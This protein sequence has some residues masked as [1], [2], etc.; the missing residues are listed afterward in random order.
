MTVNLF[1]IYY[2]S[3]SFE[4]L[5]KGF[6]PLDN[7]QSERP[8]WYEF[9]PIRTYLKNTQ[10]EE[11]AWYGFFSPKFE[12][13]TGFRSDDVRSVVEKTGGNFQVALFSSTWDFIAYFKNVF[14]QGELWHEHITAVSQEFFRQ[15]DY[16]IDLKNLVN[17]SQNSVTSNYIVAKPAYWR[18]WLYF[19]EKLLDISESGSDFGAL[20]NANTT[21]GPKLVPWKVFV[22]ERLHSVILANEPFS[23]TVPDQSISG[24]LFEHLFNPDPGTRKM[25][26]T[27]DTLKQL[28][29]STGDR[30]FLNVYEKTRSAINIKPAKFR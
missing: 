13:K 17:H 26:Q 1:Q 4:A 12:R 7:R 24:P 19:A 23:V 22:Q 15:V 30:E 10:L 5:D 29:T 9:W 16:Q 18:R 27:C 6:T 25:L 11:D 20:L 21:Y 14:E 8:D 2:D 3:S 28:Y